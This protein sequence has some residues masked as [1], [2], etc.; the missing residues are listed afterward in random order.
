MIH[1]KRGAL[2]GLCLLVAGCGSDN[3]DLADFVERVKARPAAP[4]EPIPEIAAYTPYTYRAQ[5]RRSPFTPTTPRRE[6]TSNSDIAPNPNRAREPLE[7]FPLDALR[8][9]GT[10]S[11]A[12]VTYALIQAPDGVIHR[13]RPGNH[14]GQ[15]YGEI[16]AISENGVLLTEIV[17]DGL[18]GYIRRPATL[19]PTR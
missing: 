18:G 15:N 9:V 2:A 13:L 19:A 10:I 1:F 5:D 8:L 16:D 14:I 17:P 12:G 4:I 6:V 11:R 3:S 7:A